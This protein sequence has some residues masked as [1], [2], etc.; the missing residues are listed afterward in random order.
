MMLLKTIFPPPHH[1]CHFLSHLLSPPS[2]SP[3]S[4]S[5]TPINDGMFKIDPIRIS[6]TPSTIRIIQPIQIASTRSPKIVQS[7]RKDFGSKSFSSLIPLNQISPFSKLTSKPLVKPIPRP[8][9]PWWSQYNH[10]YQTD[11]NAKNFT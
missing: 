9:S 3:R 5:V 10:H 1:S 11:K 8:K 7:K 4:F 2:P 6:T